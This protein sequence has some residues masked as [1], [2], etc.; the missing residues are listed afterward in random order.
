MIAFSGGVDSSLLAKASLLA[1]EKYHTLPP[2][3]VF[4]V[5]P[6]SSQSDIENARAV[7]R[8]IGLRL[9]EI[10][11]SGELALLAFQTN[12]PDRCYHCK[13]YR[14]S[15]IQDLISGWEKEGSPRRT[16]LDGENADD[17]GLWR[18]GEKAAAEL[19][20]RS[21]L[22]ELGIA[23]DEVRR[24]AREVELSVADRPSTPCLATRLL[25]G[26]T[27]TSRL[28]RR[29]EAAEDFLHQKGFDVCRVRVDSPVTA[30]IEVP[31]AEIPRVLANGVKEAILEE[32]LRLGF[33]AVSL[34]LEGFV[35]GKMDRAASGD[36]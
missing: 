5:S 2:V 20:V 18:P 32:F 13:K 17:R 10:D 34:D 4:A 28:L 26:M 12:A 19:G 9:I 6:T 27:P 16:L 14:F 35:S 11:S 24:L 36:E 29:I 1:A 21:P 8:E 7:A 25:Y 15:A 30:R 23:K 22:A 31:A 33:A 3:G